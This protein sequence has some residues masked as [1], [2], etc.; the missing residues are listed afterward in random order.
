MIMYTTMPLEYIFENQE[1]VEKQSVQEL[2]FGDVTM[3]VEPTGTF[4]GKII[5]LISPNPQDY[6]N[7]RFAP[8]QKIYFRPDLGG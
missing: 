4:E 2:S 1:A 3:M 5:R 7:P 8:G 6:L